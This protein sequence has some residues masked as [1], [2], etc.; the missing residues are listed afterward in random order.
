MRACMHA[1]MCVQTCKFMQAYMLVKKDHMDMQADMPI[2][3]YALKGIQ[4]FVCQMWC[5]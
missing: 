5:V 4:S 1:N 3:V 2:Q